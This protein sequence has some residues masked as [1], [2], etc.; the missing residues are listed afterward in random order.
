MKKSMSD[1]ARKIW[2]GIIIA[3]IISAI[4]FG[5]LGLYALTLFSNNPPSFTIKLSTDDNSLKAIQSLNTTG[6]TLVKTAI[7]TNANQKYGTIERLRVWVGNDTEG[8]WSDCEV[9]K[10]SANGNNKVYSNK[11]YQIISFQ[12][13]DQYGKACELRE[14]V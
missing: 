4:C 1:N 13:I 14:V 3:Y 7:E 6:E 8:Y 10:H 2:E 12:N 9:T 5:L 11:K